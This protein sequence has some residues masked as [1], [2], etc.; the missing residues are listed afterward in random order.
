MDG[1]ADCV[2][3][4]SALSGGRLIRRLPPGGRVIERGG[5]NFRTCS[6]PVCLLQPRRSA[7]NSKGA[8]GSDGRVV[9]DPPAQSICTHRPR[10]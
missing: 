8:W 3:N 10:T 5:V 1:G 4:D 9:G 7:R 2:M 6:V